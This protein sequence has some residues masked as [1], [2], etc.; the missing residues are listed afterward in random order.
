MSLT[1]ESRKRGM[2]KDISGDSN[3]VEFSKVGAG[4]PDTVDSPC[5]AADVGSFMVE[6]VEGMTSVLGVLVSAVRPSRQRIT[7]ASRRV[8]VSLDDDGAGVEAAIGC[9]TIVSSMCWLLAE[10]SSLSPSTFEGLFV[11]D[12]AAGGGGV[13]LMQVSSTSNTSTSRSG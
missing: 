2:S 7:S 6:L 1:A 5:Q 11:A 12:A 10:D 8:E 9:P 4:L 3:A 13:G